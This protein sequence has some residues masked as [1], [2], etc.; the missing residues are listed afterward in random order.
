MGNWERQVPSGSGR[1]H[2]G[3]RERATLVKTQD[4]SSHK[5][6]NWREEN[7]NPKDFV[8]RPSPGLAR[9]LAWPSAVIAG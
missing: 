7:D 6:S 2:F 1:R 3:R 4:S 8:P 5:P 9:G